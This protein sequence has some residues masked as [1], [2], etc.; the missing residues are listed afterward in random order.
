[1]GTVPVEADPA[2][3]PLRRGVALGLVAG[4]SALGIGGPSIVLA[5]IGRAYGLPAPATAWVLAAFLLGIGVSVAIGGRLIDVVGSVRVALLGVV[6]T[7]LGTAL[8]I[9][10]PSFFLI[11][12]GRLMQ[13]AGSGWM[14]VVAFNSVGD[15]PAPL[16]ARTC[17]IL[18]ATSFSFLASAPLYGALANSVIGWRASLCLG[19]SILFAAPAL[20][21]GLPAPPHRQGKIDLWGATLATL[22]AAAVAAILEA[23]ATATPPLVVGAIAVG[24]LIAAALLARH[25][26]AE[27]FGF[28]PR[29]VLQNRELM[30]LSTGAAAVQAAYTAVVVAAPLLLTT[31]AGWSPLEAGAALAP[32]S[33]V[34]VAS[35]YLCGTRGARQPAALMI[36]R[37]SVV[38][39]AGVVLAG[40]GGGIPL[41]VVLGSLLAVGP[42]AGVQAVMLARVPALAPP[43]ASGAATG[44]FN[45]VFVAGG[46]AGACAAGGLASFTD[47]RLALVIVAA[48]PLAGWAAARAARA[49]RQTPLEMVT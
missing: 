11:V 13:G 7:S 20:L 45:Y 29:A 40:V 47:V 1:L 25:L 6:V 8:V 4:T 43:S 2:F 28:L 23:P 14:V 35:A 3:S 44:A 15:V 22:T 32:G 39:A 12:C 16:R 27:P 42:Y 46:A 38:S 37:L 5:E 10:A 26:A 48:F 21:R 36:T 41:L 49:V 19:T 31:A 9:V 34:A 30:L 17:G 33:I 18:T 24:A